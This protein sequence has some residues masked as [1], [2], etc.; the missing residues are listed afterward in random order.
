[1][2]APDFHFSVDTHLFR[3][4]GELL[5]G[6]DSTALVELIKNAYDADATH[7]TVH[8]EGL[9]GSEGAITVTDDGIGM[10]P[11]V[12]NSA[13]LRIAGRYKE[14]GNRKSPRFG[15]RYTG[16]KGVGRLSAHK[17][18]KVLDVVS[19]PDPAVFNAELPPEGVRAHIDWWGMEQ[20]ATT[21]DNVGPS[22][23]V[24]PFAP[25]SESTPGTRLSLKGVRAKWTR[26]RLQGFVTQVASCLPPS[27]ILD[28]P[29]FPIPSG[30]KSLGEIKPWTRTKEDP[31]FEINF[32]G[33]L[34]VGENLWLALVD[35]SRWLLEIE[36]TAEG[37]YFNIS[38]TP[39][40]L[41]V[42]PEA[43]SYSLRR[44]HPNP[45]IGPYFVARIFSREGRVVGASKLVTLVEQYSGIRVYQE[46][47]RVVPY[48]EPH[49]DWLGLN[50][51][52]TRRI[53][54]F[55]IPLDTDSSRVLP[56]VENES[57]RIRGS[58]QYA[59]GVFLTAKGGAVLRPVVN[60]EGFL[61]DEAFEDLRTMVRN[62]VDLM[63][64]AQ[65]AAEAAAASRK[66]AEESQQFTFRPA[67]QPST[68]TEAP[69]PTSQQSTG[70][71]KTTPTPDADDSDEPT[72]R[73]NLRFALTRARQ[74]I[75]QIQ[76]SIS[77][78][79][80]LGQQVEAVA[81]AVDYAEK[82]A[83]Q[84][85]ADYAMLQVLASVGLQF[86]SFVHE[87][88]GLLSQ[89]QQLRDLSQLLPA[90]GK[91]PAKPTIT[92]GL[93]HGTEALCQ[94]L[95]RQASYL[96]EVVGPDAR[97]RRRGIFLTEAPRTSL[98]L[99]ATAIAERGIKIEERLQEG[100]KTPPIFPAELTIIFT[101]LLTNAI[102]AADEGGHVL[103]AGEASEDG[104]VS[105][106]VENTGD[107]VDLDD[108]ERWF[109]PFESTTTE[110]D[111]LLGQG[112]GLGLPITR[113]IVSDYAGTVR[114]VTPSHG[115]ST[116]VLVSLPPRRTK[117]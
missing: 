8:A 12:F 109:K 79:T 98:Q 90:D 10:S 69:T 55:N 41:E 62:G 28:P 78:D 56:E 102:K 63:T 34:D 86:A 57:F 16:A 5:V 38:P 46:G 27:Q 37:V 60:R 47:F 96:T 66:K 14:R 52:Y 19:V 104:G 1:M 70:T 49:D 72:Q 43:R 75:S 6:R 81:A 76:G 53:R 58:R 85:E 110:V 84:D 65:A 2:T 40:Q 39:A 22:L 91:T 36:A 112:M 4:L 94:A 48:G 67:P 45:S 17:L 35:Q 33:D 74:E 107:A 50:R 13:F 97:R 23:E 73:Q 117:R 115:Y 59:G 18:A 20:T 44:E 105:L 83:S 15:R 51:D 103:I 113:R 61:Q 7:V 106:R 11:E 82:T 64:R 71:E 3:E 92:R 100:T 93:R 101:N 30:I 89:A 42:T 26:A 80:N 29:P 88:N 54:G 99:L 68:D 116:A 114:F 111:V 31:G 95:T 25:T 77:F 108:S 21:L 87:V 32:S 9:L 24:H